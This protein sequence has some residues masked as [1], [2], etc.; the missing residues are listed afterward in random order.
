LSLQANSEDEAVRNCV[1]EA[2]RMR[3]LLLHYHI[4]KNAGSTVEYI[5]H[6]AFGERFVTLHGPQADS[7]LTA[8]DV[9]RFLAGNSDVL[10]ISSHHLKYPRPAAC[11]LVVF[12]LCFL[13]DP[14][15][16][17]R[18]MYQY[19][20]RV[21]AFDELGKMA[22]T[23]DFRGFTRELV[24]THPHMIND[25]Q[26]VLLAMGGAYTR[27]PCR[28]DLE[29]AL[30]VLREMA[31]PG[32]L[33]VFD[34]TLV[35]A[36]YFLRPAFPEL[37]FQYVK[38]NVAPVAAGTGPDLREELGDELY[39]QVAALN[40]LDDDL[41]ARARDEV[42][43]RYDMVPDREGRRADFN[44]RCEHLRAVHEARTAARATL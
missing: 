24:S 25:V 16:R 15:E 27:P 6:R 7:L 1:V 30:H 35:A 23:L 38:Q 32:V 17:L 3:F 5:L 39:A 9:L 12:D 29:V 19:M 28:A 33:D 44:R 8:S 36:E 40:R 13:R 2:A 10:A 14:L 20:R 22:A 18:S 43:R 37:Q 26:V 11:D 41:V 21:E 4:F 31:I 34:E 42:L